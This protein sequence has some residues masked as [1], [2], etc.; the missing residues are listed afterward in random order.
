M[1][2]SRINNR[3]DIIGSG[4]DEWGQ[5]AYLADEKRYAPTRFIDAFNDQRDVSGDTTSLMQSPIIHADGTEVNAQSPFSWMERTVVTAMNSRG[6]AGGYA[7][8]ELIGGGLPTT[9]DIRTGKVLGYHPEMGNFI[10]DINDNGDMLGGSGEVWKPAFEY[11]VKSGGVVRRGEGFN[12]AINSKGVALISVLPNRMMLLN[13]DGSTEYFDH[14]GR[15]TIGTQISGTGVT[16]GFALLNPATSDQTSYIWH[17]T[18]GYEFAS[19]VTNKIAGDVFERLSVINDSGVVA[20]VGKHNGQYLTC[21]ATP[22]PEPATL[23]ALGA[24]TFAI[25]RRRGA[26]RRS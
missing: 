21:I 5:A 9:W 10:V 26:R 1:R 20:G 13:P 8:S 14:F 18:K 22:V 17:G 7:T 11:T 24:G 4:Y 16:V 15:A 2:P 23:V 6:V 25:L 19:V 3:G 12:R